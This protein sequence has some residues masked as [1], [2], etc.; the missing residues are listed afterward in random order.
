MTRFGLI[1]YNLPGTI[2]EF[3]EYAAST[4]FDCFEVQCSDFWLQGLTTDEA[5]KQAEILRKKMDNLGLTASAI[6]AQND[7]LQPDLDRLIAQAERLKAVC[8]IAKILGTNILRVD[9]GWPKKG[10]DEARYNELMIEGFKRSIEAAEKND[11]LFALDNHGTATNDAALQIEIIKA[12]GSK[13]MGANLDTMNYRW[14]GHDLETIKRFYKL[15][16][17]YVLHTHFKDGRG[18]RQDYVGTALG[19]GEID[20]EYAVKCL[21]DSGYKGP[22]LVEYEGATDPREGYRKGLEWLR[23]RI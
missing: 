7:F 4:G 20:L 2:D 18:S 16:A 14:F 21:I 6:A 3:M 10:V 23:K 5:M 13:N 17:P 11:I 1:H 19:E 12:V 9:G 8:G 15:I 22:W